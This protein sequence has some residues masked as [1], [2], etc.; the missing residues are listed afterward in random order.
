MERQKTV[1]D[2]LLEFK[3]GLSLEEWSSNSGL[4]TAVLVQT[5]GKKPGL[6]VPRTSRFETLAGGAVKSPDIREYAPFEQ[7]VW[8]IK[9]KPES[10][11][12]GSMVAFGRATNND[13][14][15]MEPDFSKQAYLFFPSGDSFE[16][17]VRTDLATLVDGVYSGKEEKIPLQDGTVIETQPGYKFRFHTLKGFYGLIKNKGDWPVQ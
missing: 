8:E 1:G 14:V 10:P 9:S 5:H 11:F 15:L 17:Q 16:L 3:E 2:Y 4:E 6:A 12:A 7:P 13:L